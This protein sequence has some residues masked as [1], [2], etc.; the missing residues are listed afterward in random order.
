MTMTKGGSAKRPSPGGPAADG[1]A[2][3]G[4][5]PKARTRR[6]HVPAAGTEHAAA[7]EKARREM[8]HEGAAAQSLPADAASRDRATREARARIGADVVCEALIR[9]GVGV[10]FSYPGGVILPLYDVLGDY[11]ELRHVLVRHEQGGAH[12][13]DGYARA[14]GKVGVCMGTS[15]PG[16]TNLV[17]GIGTA[18][19]DSIPMVAITGNVPSALIGKDAF[20]EIDINGIPLPMT[21]H[22]YLVR[23]ADDLPRVLAEAFHIARTGRPGPVHVDITKDALQQETATP[24][25]TEA[26]VIAGLPGFRPNMDG[27]YRQLKTAAAEIAAATFSCRP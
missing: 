20:Q 1:P 14:T 4:P 10:F 17:T 15:G 7:I 19:L 27:H 26:E 22:N 23:N 18:Q 16:A 8:P 25:P 5:P 24:H 3:D 13:A 11:P 2:A 21:K 9:Q 12:A 6:S